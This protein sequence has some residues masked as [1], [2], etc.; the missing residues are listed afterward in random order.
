MP[1]GEN[2]IRKTQLD[3]SEPP[4]S[5]LEYAR[6]TYGETPET[7]KQAIEEFRDY[8]F[9]QEQ[10]NP[11]RTDDA[12]L[13]KFLRARKFNIPKAHRLLCRYYSF[14]ENNPHLHRDIRPLDLKFIG[15][16]DVLSVPPYRDQHGHR[17]MIY[18]VGNWD[19]NKYGVEE[20]FKASVITLELGILEPRCQIMG[21]IC[22]LDLKGLS[23]NHT[24]QVTPA[25]AMKMLEFVT[26]SCTM[27]IEAVHVLHQSW[28]FDMMYSGVKPFLSQKARDKLFIHGDDMESFHQHID[29]KYLPTRYGGS[30]D[31]VNFN[32]WLEWLK[33]Q[34]FIVD[35]MRSL[36]YIIDDA[37]L[38][39]EPENNKNVPPSES[40]RSVDDD[41]SSSSDESIYFTDC[42]DGDQ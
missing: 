18:R 6:I 39:I 42:E 4:E 14:K 28:Y 31:D 37:D 30:Q 10:C 35:E 34:Q 9:D 24:W 25:M 15:D 1:Y 23:L 27:K 32:E 11:H 38:A 29:P 20:L 41:D 13:L 22:I 3:L 17:M 8:I 40:G 33:T 19:P 2:D 7:R 5:V 16:D 36:G 12:F 21:G 26:K